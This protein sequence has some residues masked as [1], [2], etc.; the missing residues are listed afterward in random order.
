MSSRVPH[1]IAGKTT[2]L[3]VGDLPFL[4]DEEKLFELFHCFGAIESIRLKKSDN[5][6][7]KV[8]LSYGFVKFFA[9]EDAVRAFQEVNGMFYLG[10]RLRLGWADDHPSN[11]KQGGIAFIPPKRNDP[12]AQI[13]VTFVSKNMSRKISELELHQVFDPYRNVVD[14]V[15]KKGDFNPVRCS[16]SFV[17]F[18]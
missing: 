8:H 14:V 4:C 6:P 13:H 5:D 17:F 12:T 11:T 15:V 2:T 7:Q 16:H 1:F 3:F 10:R 18:V 9:H